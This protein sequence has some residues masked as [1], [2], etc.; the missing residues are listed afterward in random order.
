MCICVW[1]R[2]DAE[3]IEAE[4]LADGLVDK[5]IREAVKAHMACQVQGPDSFILRNKWYRETDH[6][7]DAADI[8]YSNKKNDAPR[9]MWLFQQAE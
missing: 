7:Q 1:Q 4:A 8:F 2:T 9:E 5:L 3:N 6:S